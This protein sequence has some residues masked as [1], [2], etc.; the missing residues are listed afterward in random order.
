[1]SFVVTKNCLLGFAGAVTEAEVDVVEVEDG[2]G[3]TGGDAWADGTLLV[4]AWAWDT[5][6]DIVTDGT[7]FDV[8]GG[9]AEADTE[10]GATVVVLWPEIMN[11][12][13]NYYWLL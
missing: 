5:I 10:A 8:W 7:A 2:G 1:M 11:A 6:A 3:A 4:D 12:A 13:G 9:I